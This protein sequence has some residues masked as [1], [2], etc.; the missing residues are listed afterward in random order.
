[1]N[2]E[3]KA[4]SK[5]SMLP[6]GN[7]PRFELYTGPTDAPKRLYVG[8]DGGGSISLDGG[9][10]ND[11]GNPNLATIVI[12]LCRRNADEYTAGLA[13]YGGNTVCI[14]Q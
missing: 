5:D 11:D 4:Y 14:V 3:V 9:W 12:S 10:I 6:Q 8:D 2:I 13:F 1:L 7:N